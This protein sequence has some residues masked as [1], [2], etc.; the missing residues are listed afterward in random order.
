[1]GERQIDTV[2][3]IT[4]EDVEQVYHTLE[5]VRALIDYAE[6]SDS[7]TFAVDELRRIEPMLAGLWQSLSVTVVASSELEMDP[8]ELMED[9][10]DE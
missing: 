2:F 7:D 9:I 1:M 4:K 3:D 6:E 8:T 5:L 10:A